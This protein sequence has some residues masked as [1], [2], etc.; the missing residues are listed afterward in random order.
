MV[1][2]G[3]A[4]ICTA[5]EDEY[6]AVR[7]HLEG[8]LVEHEE[9][10]TLYEIGT[11]TTDRGSLRVAIAQ[12]G[13]GNTQAG[14]ELDRAVGVF[15]PHCV[16]FVGVAGGRKDVVLGDVVV[17]DYVYDYES[18]KDTATQYFPRIKTKA[19]SYRFVQ[20]ANQLARD[21]AWQHRIRP[22]FPDPAPKAFVKPIAAGGTVVGSQKSA[23]ARFLQQHCGDAVAID[24]E[25]YGFL[26]GAYHNAPVEALVVRGISDLLSG[27]TESAD[28]HWQP[29]ASRHAAAFAFELLA[30]STTP[31]AEPRLAG[32]ATDKQ[33]DTDD[34]P[35]D[36][37]VS[38]V[39]ADHEWARWIAWQVNQQLRLDGRQPKVFVQDWNA[40][41]DPP[42]A[43]ERVI[44]V[45]SPDYLASYRVQDARQQVLSVR[46]KACQPDVQFIDLVDLDAASAAN[47]LL[48]GINAAVDERAEPVRK[49]AFEGLSRRIEATPAGPR[50]P[51]KPVFVGEPPTVPDGWFQD[52]YADIEDIERILGDAST[53]LVM[54]TGKEG[55]G[56]TAMVHRLWD[57]IRKGTSPL[58]VDGLVYLS[59]RGFLPTTPDRVIYSLASLLP[60]HEADQL[61]ST[62][63]PPMPWVE[64]LVYVL[65]ALAGRSVIVA[66]DAIEDILDSDGDITDLELR[67]IV[68]H[69]VPRAEL[70]VRLLFVGRRTARAVKHRFPDVTYQHKLE[71]G[72]PVGDAF[73]LLKA[74]D[75][76]RALNLDVVQDHDKARIHRLT[77]GS[78][79]A[80]Q[81]AYGVMA[82]ERCSVTKLLE[83]PDWLDTDRVIGHLLERA[84]EQ[85][86]RKEQR[87][88][89]ALA[90]YGRPVKAAAV[91]YLIGDDIPDLDSRAVLDRLRQL[92]LAQKDGQTFAVPGLK[93]RDYLIKQLQRDAGRRASQTPTALLHKAADYF[94]GQRHD[95][96]Q[97]LADLLP[98]LT[99]IELRLRAGDHQTAFDLMGEVDDAYLHGWG[100]STA[101]VPFL[102]LLNAERIPKDLEIDAKSMLARALMQQEDYQ[103]ATNELVLAFGLASGIRRASRRIVLREQ[104]TEAHLHLG[105]LRQ[106]TTHSRRACLAAILQF[107]ERHAMTAVAGLAMCRARAGKLDPALRLLRVARKMLRLYP[108]AVDQAHQPAM[109]FSEAWVYGQLGE[110]DQARLLVRAGRQHAARLGNRDMDGACLLAEAQLALDDSQLNSAIDLAE[111]AVTIGLTNG[112]RLLCRRSMEILAITQLADGDLDAAARAADIA[113]RNRASVLGFGLVGLAAFRRDKKEDAR[114]AFH[115]GYLAAKDRLKPNEHD[116]QFLDTYGLVACGLALLN[117]PS[118]VD[119]AVDAYRRARQLAPAVGA[120]QRITMLLKQFGSYADREVLERVC[121]AAKGEGSGRALQHG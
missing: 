98:H 121:A 100:S 3:T 6:L 118:Y 39:P 85:L 115:D 106:A 70:G 33:P 77:G 44:P 55:C 23:I 49:Q 41:T 56:K 52:R 65:A 82:V 38:H 90:V 10:G 94:A 2:L 26:Q 8:P 50:F 1:V 105:D 28:K 91:D 95:D 76:N 87:V 40:A 114:V 112:N 42:P 83:V 27:K 97:R 14:I 54:L 63:R 43:A 59:A 13:A 73:A 35:Y 67:E 81:L 61:V 78:P 4:V 18:G 24:M 7:E 107:R 48:M 32:R 12:T 20:R 88:L 19:P 45:L 22:A 58:R 68:D 60:T 113:N 46:V 86:P 119:I 89:Q 69:L 93:E 47:A 37:V 11:F 66:I 99:E 53:G 75:A 116:F 72:L 111:Q 120:V 110:R 80:L 34:R 9:R 36:F 31:T 62:V 104:L 101:L 84:Y 57:L 117:E 29:I 109:L 108:N 64:K 71:E 102:K 103:K 30:R 74:M 17:A 21:D 15:D 5:I 96:P 79:R 16:L 25:A 51:G 92:R